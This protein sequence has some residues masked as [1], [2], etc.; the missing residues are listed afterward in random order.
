MTEE[1]VLWRF[2]VVDDKQADEVKEF[3][4]GNA[5]LDSP[6]TVVVE[7]CKKFS[8]AIELL[9]RLRID[10]VILDLKDN[11]DISDDDDTGFA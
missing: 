10:L 5:V 7:T 4:D 9:D 11:T 3:I 2:L 1:K 6:N 8:E